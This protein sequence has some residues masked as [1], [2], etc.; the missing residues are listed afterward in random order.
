MGARGQRAGPVLVGTLL[1][2]AGLAGAATGLSFAPTRLF[3]LAVLGPALALVVFARAGRARR[4][5]LLGLAYGVGYGFVLLRWTID[6]HVGMF[7]TLPTVFALWFV[8]VGAVVARL[9]VLLR[10]GWW[11]VAASATWVLVEAA[12]ARVPLS[13]LEWG[14]LGVASAGLP[15]RRG[16]AVL[17][18]LGLTG[19]LV[20][21]AAALAVLVVVN[22]RRWR[23]LAVSAALLLVVTALGAVPWTASAPRLQV[24]VV[25]VDD[26]CPDVFAVDCPDLG[27]RI[28]DAFI[29]G[30]AAVADGVEL[31]FWGEGALG[32]DPDRVGEVV[33]AQAG[34]LPA[35]LVAGTSTSAGPAT[36]W[37][38]NVVYAPDGEVLDA[39]AKR[40]PVPF[41]E[42]VPWRGVLGGVA[43][44]GRLVPTDL[45]AGREAE[46]LTVP[47]GE[48][49]VRVGSVVSWEVTFSRFV[50]DVSDDAGLLATLTTQ[51]SYGTSPV[52]DQLL[53]AAQLRAAELQKPLVVAA[54]TGRSAVIDATGERQRTTALYEADVLR[55][56]VELRR[57]LTPY[58]RTGDGLAMLLAAVALVLA[59]LLGRRTPAPPPPA[60]RSRE[61]AATTSET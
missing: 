25:Q 23:A 21:V 11:V 14:Q 26:P 54:T 41:G 16:S 22:W 36:W 6:L 38:R 47:T 28:R 34:P 7:L 13:G 44:V 46:P 39:Y 27:G 17:G 33:V 43:D 31:I 12:R 1:V 45:L 53:A 56:D 37:N 8:V 42:Y 59:V 30:T 61:L 52:S 60:K 49:V 2:V 32:G 19:L 50:R 5:A 55:T 10:P 24:A 3:P 20:A 18:T 15:L 4:G 57:G 35:P 9:A 58:A 51:A 40:E 29:A 48:G